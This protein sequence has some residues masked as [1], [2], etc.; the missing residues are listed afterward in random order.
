MADFIAGHSVLRG[1]IR[2]L[3]L[4][5]IAFGA[6]M[7]KTSMAVKLL[8]M[9]LLMIITGSLTLRFRIYKRR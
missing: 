7:V 1:V 4:P 2:V 8:S 9:A 3:L 6:F 5:L